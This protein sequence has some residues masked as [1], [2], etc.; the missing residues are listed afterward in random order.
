M[1]KLLFFFTMMFS[2]LSASALTYTVT[3]P[4]GTNAC[5]I[6]GNW[7]Y[8]TTFTVMTKVNATTYTV[9]IPN[10][11]TS[12]GYKY[13]SG[14]AWGY[15]EKTSTGGEVPDRTWKAS[16]VVAKWA[17]VY[18]PIATPVDIIYNVTVPAGTNACYISGGWDSYT[19]F[20]EMTKVTETNYTITI[21]S[22]PGFLYKYCSGPD[23]MYVEKNEDGTDVSP[24]RSY[25]ANDVVAKWALIY[26]ATTAVEPV[27]SENNPIIG[28]KSNI[29]IKV[30]G[31]AKIEV[32]S[33]NGSLVKTI[34]ANNTVSI[35][36]LQ[37]GLYLLKVNDKVYK[38][39]VR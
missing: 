3:V 38:T 36:N 39:V 29:Q 14:P 11:T 1:K 23:W 10:S 13:C 37:A 12:H 24:D 2:A 25:S 21:N 26:G 31:E 18:N 15:V 35:N 17:S 20:R 9:T 30:A 19:T 8:F 7:D 16:D 27:K 32:Y 22:V 5:Y 28:G 6:A 33:Y 4:T 34:N